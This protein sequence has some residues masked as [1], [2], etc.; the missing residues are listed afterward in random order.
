MKQKL[1]ELQARIGIIKCRI[2][3]LQYNL[4]DKIENTETQHKESQNS[5]AIQYVRYKSSTAK[6]L[7]KHS[8][9]KR[10]STADKIYNHKRINFTLKLEKINQL[11][12]NID[13]I[14]SI[15]NLDSQLSE[16]VLQNIQE[17]ISKYENK[18]GISHT[19]TFTLY[20]KQT[21]QSQNQ[22]VI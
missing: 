21:T 2:E 20:I 5:L 9:Q 3:I 8:I 1:N 16:K 22:L 12:E 4:Y 7:L 15:L 10:K 18:F 14:D 19:P 17:E 11:A 13:R 6:F